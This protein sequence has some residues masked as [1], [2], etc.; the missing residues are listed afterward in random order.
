MQT[1][2]YWTKRPELSQ[3]AESFAEEKVNHDTRLYRRNRVFTIAGVA[4]LSI[5]GVSMAG[6][7]LRMLAHIM[8]GV[9]DD[10][11]QFYI[12]RL[13]LSLSTLAAG[14]ILF[15]C[16]QYWKNCL[17]Q[18]G[19]RSICST[20]PACKFFSLGSL[21]GSVAWSTGSAAASR[22]VKHTEALPTST[23]ESCFFFSGQ[24]RQEVLCY[25]LA[26]RH[27]IHPIRI[28]SKPC[29]FPGTWL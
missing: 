14:L 9:P 19:M 22:S 20:K 8:A 5:S 27:D 6:C 28:G 17:G 13:F 10:D 11:P 7:L 2:C 26:G 21:S 18:T 3:R 16:V 12:W 29:T 25:N 15:G 23:P 24:S 4:F 1:I